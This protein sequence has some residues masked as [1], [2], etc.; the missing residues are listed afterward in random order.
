MRASFASVDILRFT[1]LAACGCDAFAKLRMVAPA[2]IGL[3]L[4]LPVV[5]A[6]IG[7]DLSLPGMPEFIGCD[8]SLPARPLV[9]DCN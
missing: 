9:S 8:F 2:V 1:V 4:S 5:P 7:L 3:D 6:V